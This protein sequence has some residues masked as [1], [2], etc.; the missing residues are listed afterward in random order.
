M[1][2]SHLAQYMRLSPLIPPL[3][4]PPFPNPFSK[5]D[6]MKGGHNATQAELDY[7]LRRV[8]YDVMVVA[9]SVT[10]LPAA[11]RD[12]SAKEMAKMSAL[13]MARNLD[14]FSFVHKHDRSDDINV[15][16]F[17]LFGWVAPPTVALTQTER[18]RINKIV[19][20]IV[21]S[22]PDPFKDGDAIWK[23]I[24]PIIEE[25][26]TFVRECLRQKKA[27]YTCKAPFYVRRLNGTLRQ[28]GLPQLPNPRRGRKGKG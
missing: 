25:A 8:L 3:I 18:T 17:A 23:K 24:P 26:C 16:D 13:I 12:Y 5:E 20:H 27:A 21:A 6:T 28:I 4:P 14:A 19:G 15:T 7:G 1:A 11:G 9:K 10:A 2:A 22:K